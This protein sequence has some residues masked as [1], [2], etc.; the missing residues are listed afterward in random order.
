[1][2]DD[3]QAQRQNFERIADAPPTQPQS[4]PEAL[5]RHAEH[6]S[7][8]RTAR[9]IAA[10]LNPNK[11]VTMRD[12]AI[13]LARQGFWVFP[14]KEGTKDTPI[15]PR[16]MRLKKGEY[17]DV[18]PSS[19]TDK[20]Y[21]LWTG[22]S[23]GALNHNIGICTNDLLVFDLDNKNGKNGIEAFK[24]IAEELGLTLETVTARTPTGGKHLFYKLPGDAKARCSTS[25]LAD[26]VDIRGWHGYVVA[27][28]SRV[29]AGEY[30]WL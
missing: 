2:S 16:G 10:E 17:Y 20:V 7:R 8:E 9:A 30:V 6:L 12:R 5:T 18:V 15:I 26:G 19:D 25:K 11:S 3:K 1:M 29:P 13:Q 4:L 21:E 28:G 24:P 22:A 23:G 14:L 27:P